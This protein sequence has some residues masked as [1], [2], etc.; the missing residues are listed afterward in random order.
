MM[1]MNVIS[2]I[3]FL[4]SL[5][6]LLNYAKEV[7]HEKSPVI[8]LFLFCKPWQ[9]PYHVEH[10]RAQFHQHSIS[11]FYAR[12]SQKCKTDTQVVF[13]FSGSALAKAVRRKLMKLTPVLV[14]SQKLSNIWPGYYLDGRT[15]GNTHD[16]PRYQGLCDKLNFAMVVCYCT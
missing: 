10:T 7:A 3:L 15:L 16:Y 12:R 5:I 6:V 11:S 8:L 4:N 1:T 14:W 9:R 2:F 13:A